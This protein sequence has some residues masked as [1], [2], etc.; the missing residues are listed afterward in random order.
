MGTG[1][2]NELA[3]TDQVSAFPTHIF[4]SA[5]EVKASAS[6]MNFHSAGEEKDF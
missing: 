1:G 4:N 5:G 3:L 2:A 6:S